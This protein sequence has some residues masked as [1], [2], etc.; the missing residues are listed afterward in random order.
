MSA[1]WR[2]F[3][4]MLTAPERPPLVSKARKALLTLEDGREIID[5]ISSW[6]V[7]SHG[8]CEPEI[9]RAVKSQA[10]RLDQVLFANFSHET[11]ELLAKE[12]RSLLPK[13]LSRVF[14]SDNGSTSVEAALK[15]AVQSW[16]QKGFPEKNRFLAFSHSYHGDTAGAMSVGGPGPFTAPYKPL[17]FPALIAR[18][19]RFS[20]DEPRLFWEDLERALERE[21]GLVAAVIIEPFIQGA[22]GM[23]I[24]PKEAV[25][26]VCRA[27]RAA[28][29][30]LIF[31]EVMTGFGR[32]GSLFAFEQLDI[33]PDILCL[34]KGLTGG[35]LPLALTVS[36]E[37]IYESFLS[38]KKER[39]LLHGHS[40]TGNPLSCA[41]ALA[42]LRLLKKNRAAIQKKWRGIEA[43]HRERGK[44]LRESAGF[45]ARFRD[46]RWK[47]LVAAAE[48]KSSS[49]YGSAFAEEGAKKALE[50]GVFLRPLGGTVYI[51]PPYSITAEELHQSWDALESLFP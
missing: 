26:R 27:A 2:P 14:F 30:Y 18:Q 7:I 40:F 15:T 31:D 13:K 32:T 33:V 17:L 25:E 5:A 23:V 28:G 43:I 44:A 24:W 22:G 8:H 39:A 29:A 49:G 50:R 16:A 20:F 1:I 11:A 37:E 36:S 21:R 12:L 4:Q 38:P 9:M 46:V 34:S 47:G 51:L 41:A 19:G 45:S 10:G 6:W 42:N 35:A 48:K 3:T